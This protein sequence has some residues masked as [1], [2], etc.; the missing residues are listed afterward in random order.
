V[1]FAIVHQWLAQR[2]GRSDEPT[3]PALPAH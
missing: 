1:V 2:R 3:P